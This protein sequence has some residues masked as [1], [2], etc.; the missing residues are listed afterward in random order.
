MRLKLLLLFL[1][2][3]SCKQKSIE[4]K[5][6]TNDLSLLESK[7]ESIDC[8]CYDDSNKKPIKSISFSDANSISICGYEENNEYS[9]FSIFDCKTQK[10]I[11]SYD[12]TQTC[13]VNF[14]NDKLY[15]IELS[16]LPTNDNWDWID[17]EIT[18]EIISTQ[19]N[20]VVS[21]GSKPLNIQVS[22]SEK[23]QTDFLNLLETE[24]YKKLEIDEIIGRL[25]VLAI[26]GNERAIKK[27][28]S[29]ESDT[30]YLLDGAFAEQYKE[31]IA[32]I[33][34]RKNFKK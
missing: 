11:S 7:K 24:N 33:E 13:R 12:A 16:K 9:E 1:I 28:Y 31:A 26:I 6:D 27:L 15:I 22:I 30:N 20:K 8:K 32:I 5:K 34:W 4:S 3:T 10:V 17:V 21:L 14:E 2:F 19:Y 29:L 18:E 23:T 25:E